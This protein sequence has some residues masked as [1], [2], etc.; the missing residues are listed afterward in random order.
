MNLEHGIFQISNL[1]IRQAGPQ[2]SGWG[3]S[4]SGHFGYSPEGSLR[5]KATIARS[6]TDRKEAIESGAF[7]FSISTIKRLKAEYDELLKQG[8]KTEVLETAKQEIARRDIHILSGHNW[9]RVLG[10]VAAGTAIVDEVL[11][12]PEDPHVSFSVPLPKDESTLPTYFQ[13]SIKEITR[14]LVTSGGVSPALG[15]SPGFFIPPESKVPNAVKYVD[16]PGST[17]GVRIRVVRAAVLVEMSLV[18]RSS[19]SETSV[20]VRGFD[21]YEEPARKKRVKRW[22]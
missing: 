19:Y 6:G 2:G 14:D 22:L 9:N 10:S 7:N 8:A 21:M 4:I 18:F 5:R 17:E 20:D 12:D 11:D 1:E 3:R 16:E 13:D 15:V